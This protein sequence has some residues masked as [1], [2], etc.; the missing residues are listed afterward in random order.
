MQMWSDGL[1]TTLAIPQGL[2]YVLYIVLS[3]IGRYN[4]RA[5]VWRHP[6]AMGQ[7]QIPSKEHCTLEE[8]A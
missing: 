8:T 7:T 2:P 1:L 6:E 5:I 4:K 3:D